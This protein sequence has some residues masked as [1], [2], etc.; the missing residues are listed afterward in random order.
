MIKRSDS[1]KYSQTSEFLTGNAGRLPVPNLWPLILTIWP[2]IGLVYLGYKALLSIIVKA[3]RKE[4]EFPAEHFDSD[5]S[6]Y[7]NALL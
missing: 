1:E 5:E 3:V 7:V 4:N 2:L 6:K